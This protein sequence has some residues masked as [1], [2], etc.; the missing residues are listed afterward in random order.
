MSGFA[1]EWG[2]AAVAFFLSFAITAGI[3]APKEQCESSEGESA[4]VAVTTP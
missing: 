4:S 3:Y 2:A 1:K